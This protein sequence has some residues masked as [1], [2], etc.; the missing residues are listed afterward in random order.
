MV[1]KSKNKDTFSKLNTH[2]IVCKTPFNRARSSKL[3]CSGRC[4]QFGYNHKAELSK[5]RDSASINEKH[6]SIKLSQLDFEAYLINFQKVKRYKELLKR[7]QKFIEEMKK[8]DI[9]Q[10][11]GINY[12]SEND[13]YMKSQELDNHEVTEMSKLKKELKELTLLE[14]T[15]L[16]IEQWS[17]LKLLHKSLDNRVLFKLISNFS[18]EYIKELSLSVTNEDIDQKSNIKE[19]FI[20]H[21]NY[22]TEG[23]VRIL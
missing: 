15:Y 22:L 19:K 21:C 4:K 16:T 2:C 11:I 17:F 12:N 10:E 9:R 23:N 6:K 1:N 3:Y 20:A 13:V 8:S 5:M 7:N 18:K 14:P